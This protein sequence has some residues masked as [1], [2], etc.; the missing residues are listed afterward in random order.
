MAEAT[1]PSVLIVSAYSLPHLG[2]VEV[3]VAQQACTLA[4]LG[5][6]VTVVS[7][8]AA[9]ATAAREQVDGYEIVRIPAWNKLEERSGIA[10][11]IW[12]PAAIW[13]LGRLVRASD[14][15]HVHDVYHPQSFVAAGWA[16]LLRRPLFVTQHVAI[17]D[18]DKAVVR[19]IQRLLYATAA[20]LLW[21]LAVAISVY[22]PIV[23]AFISGHGVPAGKIRLT[24]NGVDTAEFRPGDPA[25]ARATRIK[26]GLPADQP[27]VLFV[28]RL[29][30]KKG[31]H[32]LVAAR[33]PEY[34][35][36]LVG[37]GRIPDVIPAGVT[38]LG[39]VDRGELL[40]LYQASD[41]FALPAVGEMLTLAM[42]EAMSC[43]LPVVTTDDSGY[44][45]Y[46]LDP[47]GVALV[48]PEPGALRSAILDILADPD[49]RCRMRAYSRL[50]AEERFDWQRN[51]AAWRYRGD[52][53]LR[54]GSR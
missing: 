36:A 24:G 11:P 2:G 23:E 5:H 3:V 53:A 8:K 44:D 29:V 32:T 9:P 38:F 18:H 51:A 52:R 27:V 16:R 46:A 40:S 17:V 47:D 37:P 34:H 31:V 25:S 15:V 26:H 20:R 14:V 50:L 30:P 7:G 54:G 19:L 1:R 12:S 21:R 28:G 4:A 6:R 33:G 43:G 22:N 41:I 10:L 35:I 13:R 48:V 42:Q 45:R 39:P 49:R